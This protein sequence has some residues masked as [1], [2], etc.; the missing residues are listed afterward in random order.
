MYTLTLTTRGLLHIGDGQRI[1]RKEYIFNTR[2]ET[3]SFMK[4]QAFFD[5]LIRNHLVEQFEAFCKR[6]G[7]DLY[8]FLYKECAL[9]EA[10][11]APAIG[12]Q[13]NAGEALDENHTLKDISRFMRDAQGRAYIP[14][15]SVKGALRTVLLYRL[16]ASEEPQ[17]RHIDAEKILNIP[18]DKRNERNLTLP[19][20]KYLN[21][22][23]LETKKPANA[24][25]SLMRGIQVSDSEPIPDRAMTLSLKR[26]G[27]TTGETHSINLCRECIAPGESIRFRLTL[28]QAILK[29]RITIQTIMD[30]INAFSAYYKQTYGKHFTPPYGL[31]DP[32]TENVLYLGGGAGFF[33]KSL[34]YPYLGEEQGLDFVV[35][36]LSRS[37]RAHHHEWDRTL[38]ISPRTLKYGTYRQRMY[39]FG[40]CEVSIL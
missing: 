7:G 31:S 32:G 12:Y 6:V 37:F 9:T 34:A 14:G 2:K 35:R 3:V 39:A 26:D 4:E 28:D 29:G 16:I 19:E 38:G 8:S 10:Q 18:M 30:A 33:A 36:Y 17:R 27:F 25:N 15:S 21:V 20:E 1:P 5:L 23:R 24:V 40:A 13:V 11:I 22:L